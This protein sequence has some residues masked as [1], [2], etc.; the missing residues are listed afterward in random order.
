MS[1]VFQSF[2]STS[3]LLAMLGIVKPG[4]RIRHG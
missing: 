4:H 1:L 3:F 2:L